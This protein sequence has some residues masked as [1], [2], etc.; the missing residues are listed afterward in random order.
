MNDKDK[1][2]GYKS[3]KMV[4]SYVAMAILTAG[5]LAAG[6]WGG[7]QP[8]F[9]EFIAGIL[10]C[11]SIYIGGNTAVRWISSSKKTKTK[12]ETDGQPKDD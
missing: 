7:L 12:E 10:G 8:V 3:R 9:G 11:A 6:K 5:F 2:G 4:M 1:D